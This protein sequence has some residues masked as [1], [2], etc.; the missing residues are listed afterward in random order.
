MSIIFRL[1]PDLCLNGLPVWVDWISRGGNALWLLV[2]S[3][4]GLDPERG[5]SSQLFSMVVGV[6]S[7]IFRL[8]PNLCGW[9]ESRE[10]DFFF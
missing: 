5:I 1:D 2:D 6:D 4:F 10:G 3:F 9:I 7:F 8:D